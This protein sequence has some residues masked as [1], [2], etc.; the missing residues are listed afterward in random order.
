MAQG[1]SSATCTLPPVFYTAATARVQPRVQVFAV[2]E[3]G[4]L[5]KGLLGQDAPKTAAGVPVGH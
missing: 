4:T 3:E 5:S 1:S 2:D